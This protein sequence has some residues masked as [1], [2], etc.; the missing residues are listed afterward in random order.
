ME[1]EAREI[2][3]SA[4]TVPS[5]VRG[6]LAESIHRRFAEFGGIE[7]E[8]PGRNAMREPPGFGK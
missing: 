3:R 2:L 4:L 7:L 8:L 1:E 6:N 5:L